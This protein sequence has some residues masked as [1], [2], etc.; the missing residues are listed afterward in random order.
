MTEQGPK[1]VGVIGVGWGAHVQVPALRAAKGFEPVALCARTPDRLERV[2]AKLGI[3]ETS[4]DWQ[5]FVTRDDLDVISVATPNVLHR[6]MTL[7]ALAAGKPVLCE[8]PLAGDLDAAREMVRAAAESSLPTAC[9]FENRWNPDWLAV[10][11]RVRSGFLGTQYLARVSRS[12]SY[13]HPSHPLQAGWM[14]DR[15]QG[16]GYLAGMLVHDL[17]FLCS[18]LGQPVSVCAEVRTTEPERERPDGTILNV[19]ADDTAALLMRMESGVTAVLSVSVM[20]AHADH[21][22][23]ELFGSDGT[24]I[25]DGDLRSAAYS[26]G[27]A[28]DDGLNRLTVAD[29]EPAY[30]EK[31]PSG[32]AG[33]A[34]RAMALMLEDWLP[35]FDGAPS[36]AATFEDGLLSL[37]VIDAAHRSTEGGG[38][39]PVQV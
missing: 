34:S 24:I 15:D 17:D 1:R 11:D 32:L 36:S 2:A 19:T 35:A 31:L 5:S 27:L 22:R 21:Y 7:A 6:D 8:K 33:H 26:A 9:C 3:E 10:A 39:E 4:T 18:L 13:W 28:T 30:P 25:G 20:G 12:A 37:A 23:L 29:R 14:Y 16:G 38:W